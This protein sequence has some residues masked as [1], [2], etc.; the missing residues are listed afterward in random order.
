[1]Q[2]IL[3][4]T[5]NHGKVE[6]LLALLQGLPAQLI[7][8]VES[9]LALTVVEDG[10]TYAENAIKKA[11]AFRAASG[12]ISLADDSGLEVA[13]LRGAPGIRSARFSPVPG[14]TDADRR[15]LLL[16]LLQEHA[17][18]WRARFVSVVAVAVPAGPVRTF[19]GLCEGEIIMEERGAFGFGYDPIFLIPPIGRTMAEL[20]MAE[21]N[22]V[23]HR[24]NAV[25]AALPFL[26]TCLTER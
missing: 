26:R 6:E 9:G 13:A 8:P 23:S 22:Q 17:P 1:M 10:D 21:K 20:P 16:E 14:A 15:R 2:K 18:P 7:A 4:A 12:L 3:L 25:R 5:L 19:E 24:A 11:R